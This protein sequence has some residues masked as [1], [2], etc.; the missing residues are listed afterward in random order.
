MPEN[1]GKDVSVEIEEDALRDD[2]DTTGEIEKLLHEM[3]DSEETE[4]AKIAAKATVAANAQIIKELEK[5]KKLAEENMKNYQYS[6]AELDNFKKRVAQERQEA[7][8]FGIIPFAREI[9]HVV[10]NL[11][12]ALEHLENA[13]KDSLTQ[14]MNMTIDMFNNT[15]KQFGI[16]KVP[17]KGEN[18]DPMLHEAISMV[19][20]PDHEPNQIIKVLQQG[21]ILNDRLVRPSQVVVNAS[22]PSNAT[23]EAGD[24]ATEEE[25]RIQED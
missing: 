20:L 16:D 15:L 22:A 5:Y 4:P 7:R 21:Y 8:K 2:V 19:T 17:S 3:E 18:F 6:V 11:E 25:A 14:G 23:F 24:E 12:R 13:D 10:D 1:N 9:L